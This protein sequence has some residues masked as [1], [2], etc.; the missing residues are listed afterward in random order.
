ML[1]LSNLTPTA[2]DG[3][4]ARRSTR[5]S[6]PNPFLDGF[7]DGNGGVNTVGTLEYSY[8][9]DKD[10][11]VT[12]PGTYEDTEIKR[13]PHKGEPTKKLTGDAAAVVSM[14]R[15]AADKLGIGCSIVVTPG[16]RKG[17]LAIQY[18]GKVR[19]Q[20]GPRDEDQENDDDYE[21]DES[22]AE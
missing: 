13:G 14:L 8:D 12:V 3:M 19:K 20:Y 16:K 2:G 7:P 10:F 6:G 4:P 9:N 11:V 18:L 22:A 15:T 21:L 17:T 1:D 5:T